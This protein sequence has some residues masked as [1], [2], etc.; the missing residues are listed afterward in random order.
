VATNDVDIPPNR[1]SP[2]DVDKKREAAK[3][4]ER[5]SESRAA[6]ESAKAVEA[7]AG[8]EPTHRG[9]DERLTSKFPLGP[10][11]GELIFWRNKMRSGVV[12][13][14]GI[15][16]YLLIDVFDYTLLS[17]ESWAIFALLVLSMGF[18]VGTQL[19]VRIRP[20]TPAI[21]P[22][23][24]NWPLAYFRLNPKKLASNVEDLANCVN[25]HLT[26][27]KDVF[28][29][30]DLT[31]TAKAAG[32]AFAAAC[33]TSW[34]NFIT[35]CFLGFFALFTLPITYVT[36][37]KQIDDAVAKFLVKAKEI[38]GKVTQQ[39]P[40]MARPPAGAQRKTD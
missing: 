29:S 20:S 19:L 22:N 1:T 21:D 3:Q 39:L 23:R 34:F 33:V 11:V 32:V 18:V 24:E 4:T 25:E 28:Y 37:Q 27:L 14:A 12:F 5:A 2:S 15:L 40:R 30:R 26:Q 16:L 9:G 31:T 38:V 36:Y 6:V 10:Q 8:P 17:L 13:S 35:I 7:A